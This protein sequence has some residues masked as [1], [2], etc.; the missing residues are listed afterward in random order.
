MIKRIDSDIATTLRSATG[1]VASMS[2]SGLLMVMRCAEV[3]QGSSEIPFPR[4][5]TMQ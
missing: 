5:K 2:V 1:R 3:P 4:F